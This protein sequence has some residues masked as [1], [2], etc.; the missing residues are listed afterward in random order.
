MT[1][2]RKEELRQELMELEAREQKNPRDL[3][4]DGGTAASATAELPDLREMELLSTV[5]PLSAR[6]TALGGLLAVAYGAGDIF[7]AGRLG[8][9]LVGVLVVGAALKLAEAEAR[10]DERT[11][12]VTGGDRNR[13]EN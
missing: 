8:V 10:R 6:V 7:S 2:K 11:R 13:R 3:L 9:L 5:W 4:A 12:T 1:K